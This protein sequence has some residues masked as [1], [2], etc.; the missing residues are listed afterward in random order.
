MTFY[1]DNNP[2]QSEIASAINYLLA[3]FAQT[4]AV[5][6]NSGQITSSG[7]GVVSYLYKY[8]NVKYADSF[9]GTVNFSN[10]PTGRTYY[11]LRNNDSAIE[12]TNPADYVWTEVVGGFG[13]TK[14]IYY[15]TTRGAH[16]ISIKAFQ[17]F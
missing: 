6:P 14:N 13:T 10:L 16:F 1:V 3:N 17:H 8:L 9:D 7:Y 15:I 12:S 4:T 5:N 11:G 2:S